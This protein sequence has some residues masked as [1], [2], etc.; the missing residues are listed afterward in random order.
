MLAQSL[1]T[2]ILSLV[3]LGVIVSLCVAGYWRMDRAD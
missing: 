3:A 1:G 2:S